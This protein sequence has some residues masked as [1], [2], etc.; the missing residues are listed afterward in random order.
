MGF[1]GNWVAVLNE[2][3]LSIWANCVHVFV[4]LFINA[5]LYVIPITADANAGSD[6]H[7]KYVRV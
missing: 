1:L 7:V 4:I 2:G 5:I 3:I 6:L